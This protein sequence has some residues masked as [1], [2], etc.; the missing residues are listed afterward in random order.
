M[1]KQLLLAQC[2]Q[3]GNTI[4]VVVKVDAIGEVTICAKCYCAYRKA[5]LREPPKTLRAA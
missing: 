5:L 4:Y 2:K 1:P 3:H